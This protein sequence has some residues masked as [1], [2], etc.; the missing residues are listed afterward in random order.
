MWNF[1]QLCEI[2]DNLCEIFDNLYEMLNLSSAHSCRVVNVNAAIWDGQELVLAGS[3]GSSAR[4]IYSISNSSEWKLLRCFMINQRN[5]I[6]RDRMLLYFGTEC[7]YTSWQKC[8]YSCG[9]FFTSWHKICGNNGHSWSG[10][11]WKMHAIVIVHIRQRN[12]IQ[13]SQ[14]FVLLW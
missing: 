8:Y 2:F 14:G 4:T 12:V 10:K 3:A 13:W 11:V 5:V 7:Y 6:L 1:W 9:L